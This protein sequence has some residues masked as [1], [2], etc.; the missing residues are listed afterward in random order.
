MFKIFLISTNRS[1]LE[2]V[3]RF[4]PVEEGYFKVKLLTSYVSIRRASSERPDMVI[5]VVSSRGDENLIDIVDEIFGSDVILC[6]D[7]T[8]SYSVASRLLKLGITSYFGMP[9]EVSSF[10]NFLRESVKRWRAKVEAEKLLEIRREQFDFSKFLG[11]SESIKEVM[12][13][14]RRAVENKNL[15]ILITGETGTGKSL[16][17]RIIHQNTY[18]DIRPF[19]EVNCPSIPATLL[20]SELF[21]YEKGAF[22]DARER[23]IGLFEAANGGTVFLDEIGDLDLNLQAKILEVIESKTFRRIGGISNLKF[24]GRIIAATN[25]D[26][27]RAV[28]EGKFRRDLYYRLMIL[29]IHIPPLRERREDIFILAEHFINEFN[30][31]YRRERPKIK[32]LS[33]ETKKL[34]WDFDWTG[35]V[36]QLRNAIERAVILTDNEYLTPDDFSFLFE[37]RVVPGAK[38][39]LIGREEG[40]IQISMPVDDASIQNVEREVIKMV[41]DKLSWNKSRAARVLGISRP[42]LDRLIRKYGIS[43]G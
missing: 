25:K 11:K 6:L 21:G 42:R 26:L 13:L 43:R 34:F 31:L 15:T 7:Y 33:E 38:V 32:G 39:D 1:A 8:K 10:S 14:V 37:K 24:S 22:T 30:E 5:L 41:L 28:N 20:E 3:C 9:E 40:F 36:R 29:P 16:L 12:F 19:V 2:K 23:K 18:Q 4:I 35:N 27:E 17:A